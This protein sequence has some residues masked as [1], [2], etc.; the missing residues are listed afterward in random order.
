MR[1]RAIVTVALCLFAVSLAILP[2]SGQVQVVRGFWT[3]PPESLDNLS[4]L[5][6][7]IKRANFNTIFLVVFYDGQTIFPSRVFP[8]LPAYQGQ[9]V[10]FEFVRAAHE[11][12]F[13]VYAAVNL[14]YWR[15]TNKSSP[16]ADQHPDW[17]ERNAEG[18]VVGDDGLPG[19]AWV[20][21]VLPEV[22]AALQQLVTELADQ[23]AFDGIAFDYTRFALGDFLGY[24]AAD[25]KAFLR[26]YRIDPLDLDPLGLG[27]SKSDRE[28]LAS[29]QEKQITD[30]VNLLSG[31]FRRLRPQGKVAAT[32]IPDYYANRLESPVR[33]DW[34][35]WADKGYLDV[36]I[37]QGI[38]FSGPEVGPRLTKM[39]ENRGVRIAPGIVPD[40]TVDTLSGP[41]QVSVVQG[42]GLVNYVIWSPDT[43]AGRRQAL[44]Q[45]GGF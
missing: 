37:P 1:M 2:V 38:T 45:F 29:W 3:K 43:V 17:L 44:R 24:A 12:G 32:V 18:Q 35:T 7:N 40:F 11:Q 10:A 20:S 22:W 36:L 16:L 15:S 5:L 31:T 21:P 8:R 13:Q 19:G 33:Q 42:L 4:I 27:T 23:Y 6:G 41:A 34:A 9:D 25:R 30:L 28:K 26:E 39:R 14:L